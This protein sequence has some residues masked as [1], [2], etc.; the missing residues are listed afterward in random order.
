MYGIFSTDVPCG[1][2]G[3]TGKM[4]GRNE[5]NV[6]QVKWP[7]QASLLYRNAY[8]CGAALI[9]NAWVVTAANCLKKCVLSDPNLI[10]W[11]EI[12]GEGEARDGKNRRA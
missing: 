4:F 6:P 8:T 2:T 10:F 12:R 9:D 7:W 3:V 5:E 1:K 11:G